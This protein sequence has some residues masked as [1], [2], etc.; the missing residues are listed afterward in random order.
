MCEIQSFGTFAIL[1]IFSTS[2]RVGW[3]GGCSVCEQLGMMLSYR[4]QH[5]LKDG[6]KFG[7]IRSWN[8]LDPNGYNVQV[9]NFQYFLKHTFL[10]RLVLG[11]CSNNPAFFVSPSISAFQ[12]KSKIDLKKVVKHRP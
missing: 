1:W 6:H 12:N 7:W 3:G 9:R 4:N 10:V 11:G 2:R 5:W 8:W